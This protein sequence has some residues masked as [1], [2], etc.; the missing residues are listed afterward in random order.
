M[1]YNEKS[2]TIS[3]AKYLK[4]IIKAFMVDIIFHY[5]SYLHYE[6]IY[7]LIEY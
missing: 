6:K 3:A 5:V 2:M 1:L 7:I 4:G